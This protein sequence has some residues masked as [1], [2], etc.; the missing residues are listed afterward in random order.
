M[1]KIDCMGG[2]GYF[3]DDISAMKAHVVQGYTTITND[4]NDD[5]AEGTMVEV[6]ANDQSNQIYIANDNLYVCMTNGAHRTINTQSG[7]QYPEV[8]VQLSSLST[9]IG[10]TDASKILSGTTISGKSGTMTN[11][12]AWSQSLGLSGQVTIPKGYH[13]G[14]GK[15]TRQYSTLAGQVVTPSAQDQTLQQKNKIITGNIT[16]LGDRNL[17]ASNIK[18]GVSL[19]GVTGSC[20]SSRYS[21]YD[22]NT[23][24]GALSSGLKYGVDFYCSFYENPYQ[25][26]VDKNRTIYNVWKSGSGDSTHNLKNKTL[27]SGVAPLEAL[28]TNDAGDY[29][30]QQLIGYISVDTVNVELYKSIVMSVSE[31][32]SSFTTLSKLYLCIT[33]PDNTETHTIEADS[34]NTFDISGITGRWYLGFIFRIRFEQTNTIYNKSWVGKITKIE[35]I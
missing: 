16:C 21:A 19:F 4:Q 25:G 18:H 27:T 12:G 14:T 35:F 29:D 9:E 33:N 6:P 15:I 20:P 17:A 31:T 30:W 8:S 7:L 11:N 10:A 28:A 26:T 32:S 13:D 34:N 23:F 2:G 5:I 24:R 1:I 3:S 22:G